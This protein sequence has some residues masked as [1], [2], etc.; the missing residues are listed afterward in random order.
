MAEHIQ[1][2]TGTTGS[3]LI[4]NSDGSINI[5][6]TVGVS[7]ITGSIVIGSVSAHVDTIYVQSGDNLGITSSIGSSYILE[8]APNDGTQNNSAWK[9]EYVTSGTST[10]VTGSSVGSITQFIGAGSFVQVRLHDPTGAEDGWLME[11]SCH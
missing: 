11:Q 10:G 4:V 8:V 7:N 6:G 2:A 5:S 3:Y 9:F 1:D